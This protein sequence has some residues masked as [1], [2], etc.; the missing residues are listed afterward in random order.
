MSAHAAP[1]RLALR[2]TRIE[3]AAKDIHLLEFRP[4]DGRPLPP[5]EPGAH[6][7]LHLA[8]GLIR[9]YSLAQPYEA[10]AGY[11]VGV[12]RDARSR[13]GSA[14]VH[15]R[16]RVGDL[17]DIAAP[18][19]LFA[20]DESAAHSVLVAGGI[21]ITPI[22]CMAQRLRARARAFEIH[23]AVRRRDEAALLDRL[24][25]PELRLHVDEE[26]GRILDVAAIVAGA[27]ADAVVYGC[28]PAPMLEAFEAAAR[29]RPG[30]AWRVERFTPA[31]E[32]ASE[33]GF[34]VRLAR[35]NLVVAVP[36]RQSILEALRS[37]GIA[38]QASC[39]QGICGTCETTVLAGTPDHRDSLLSDEERRSNKVM[40]ICC[41]GSL[42]SELVLDL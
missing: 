40:M 27:R 17:V 10:G 21:G 42:G 22:A 37:A 12:K 7:E 38:V 34:Q 15:D 39:E 9:A 11:V 6:V 35:S 1:Q 2:L 31:Q 36:P 5:Y 24:Q 33:G 32:P 4:L 29:S 18:R 19:N 14:F 26:R 16:L 3:Y 41:S 25:G 20:L 23:Y 30:L 13:G 28:G 8:N